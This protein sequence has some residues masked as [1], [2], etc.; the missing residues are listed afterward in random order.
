MPTSLLIP[1]EVFGYGCVV[2]FFMAVLI[3]V[4]MHL[5]TKFTKDKK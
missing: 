4:L 3:K 1:L 2:A 5:I